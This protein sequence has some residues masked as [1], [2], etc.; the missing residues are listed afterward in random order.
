MVNKMNIF[1]L[2]FFLALLIV[3]IVIS[4]IIEYQRKMSR[5]TGKDEQKRK[6]PFDQGKRYERSETRHSKPQRNRS[7][8]SASKKKDPDDFFEDEED[9]W[10]QYDFDMDDYGNTKWKKD[11][12][13]KDN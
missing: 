1:V 13:K 6:N 4:G 10:D 11:R 5:Y 3:V 9:F 7:E 12:K 8:G 2:F